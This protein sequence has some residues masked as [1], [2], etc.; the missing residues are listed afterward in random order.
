MGTLT[1]SGE[2]RGVSGV[3]DRIAETEQEVV[4]VDYKTGRPPD[5]GI[6][7]VSI[8][9]LALYGALVERLYPDRPVRTL[10]LYTRGPLIREVSSDDR[11]K[12][13]AVLA[14]D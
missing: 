14:K 13:L 1:V 7:E 8:F 2:E 9:Q 5:Y 10:I 6:P 3:I 11:E 12:A 4:I